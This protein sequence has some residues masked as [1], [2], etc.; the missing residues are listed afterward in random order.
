M[1]D[2]SALLCLINGEPGAESVQRILKDCTISAVNVAEVIAK[3]IDFGDAY[4]QLVKDI[5]DL[6]LEIVNMD[7]L[8]AALSGQMRAQTKSA[9]LS[10]GDRA[11]LALA[12][13]TGATALTSD[14]A[15]LSV[16]DELGISIQLVR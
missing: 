13:H 15:W 5:S 7:F 10:L 6:D 2:A 9:G 4:A 16:A 11:C 1:L 8:Q 14:Q 12:K 3:R